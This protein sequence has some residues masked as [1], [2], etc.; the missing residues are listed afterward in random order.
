MHAHK[1][2]LKNINI[3]IFLA[4]GLGVFEQRQREKIPKTGPAKNSL[5]TERIYYV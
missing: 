1:S 5:I 4:G 2:L 3:V